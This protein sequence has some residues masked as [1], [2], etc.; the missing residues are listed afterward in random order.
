MNTGA[1][2]V[3]AGRAPHLALLLGLLATV[4]AFSIDTFFPSLRAIAAE[5]GLTQLQAQQTITAYLVPYA[6]MSLV[7]GS[8]S[9]ALGRRRVILW[10]LGLYVLASL[11]CALAG[12]FAA[13]LAGRA[14]QG[15][16]A[17]TGHIVGR[18]IIRDRFAGAQAQRLMS[19]MTVIFGLGP[20][21]APVIGGWLHVAFGW[22]SVFGAMA[23]YG[24]VLGVYAWR[25]LPETHAA[26]QRAPLHVG[27]LARQLWG[28]AVHA[29]FLRLAY[30]SSLCFVAM[31]MYMG[32]APA[33]ILDHWQLGETQFAALTLP[34]I[35]G[36]VIAGYASGRMAGRVAPERQVRLGYGV[37]LL[38]ELAMFLLQA[39]VADPPV[40][41]QQLLLAGSSAGI[42]LVFPIITLTIFEL[43]PHARG[44]TSSLQSFTSLLL[45]TLVMG[46]A[47]PLLATSMATLAG[48]SLVA[49]LGAWM[50]WQRA[51]RHARRRSVAGAPPAP[52]G[53]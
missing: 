4:G 39:L 43:F 53:T 16:V 8:L 36:Y 52:G 13:L 19:A 40:Y 11:A 22:R 28:I 35:G 26:A 38:L 6:V 14:L 3:A 20:A 24:A 25:C 47:A 29:Q 34:I 51:Q 9:D 21:L 48:V 1:P 44:A 42:Q 41:L 50:L 33:I 31:Q 7:H 27:T 12:H 23:S 18:A 46:V 45:G 5:F 30:A 2:A 37:L 15:V 32:A 49:G 10:G 17:G